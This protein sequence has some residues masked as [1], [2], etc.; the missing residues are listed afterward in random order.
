MVDVRRSPE[1]EHHV[2]PLLARLLTALALL[3]AVV[4]AADHLHLTSGTPAGAITIDGK[5]DDW[6][7][8]LTPVGSEP[9]A[10]QIVNDQNTLYL[11]LTASDP[12]VRNQIV[13][14]GLV[15]WFDESGGTRKRLGIRYPVVEAG[16]GGSDGHRGGYGGGHRGGGSSGGSA[17]GGADAP[18]GPPDDYEPPNRIDI[19]GPGKDDARSLTSDHASGVEA[20]LRVSDGEVFYELKVPLVTSADHPYAINT[21]SGKTIGIGFETPKIEQSSGEAPHGG[22]GGYGRGGG[23]GGHGGMH[24][25]GMHGGGGYQGGGY[26]PPKPLKVWATVSL[27]G[28]PAR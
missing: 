27:S 2:K 25:G 1:K 21:T 4:S 22:G 10:V 8:D 5:H 19:L 20:A 16:M 12:A 7:G 15:V 9:F 17:S 18:A 11:R 13:R 14:R 26:Q 28:S 24:G 6:S 23:M 3:P